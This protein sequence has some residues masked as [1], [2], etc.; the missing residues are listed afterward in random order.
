MP[1]PYIEEIQI[2]DLKY[3]N[4]IGLLLKKDEEYALDDR[5]L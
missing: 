3:D 2:V 1:N 4:N 5:M